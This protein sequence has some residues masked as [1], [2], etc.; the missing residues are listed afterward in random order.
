MSI[1]LHVVKY[2]FL[3]LSPFLLF[4]GMPLFVLLP[5]TT[6]STLP[7]Q[8]FPLLLDKVPCYLIRRFDSAVSHSISV[9]TDYVKGAVL[10]GALVDDIVDS[11]HMGAPCCFR[12]GG[13]CSGTRCIIF[14]FTSGVHSGGAQS[15][16]PFCMKDR[17]GSFLWPWSRH[18]SEQ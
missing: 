2:M 14:R 7:V 6:C 16:W 18:H 15:L 8:V 9:P 12:V 4:F 17:L 5:F 3:S 1:K 11:V 13:A 10:C